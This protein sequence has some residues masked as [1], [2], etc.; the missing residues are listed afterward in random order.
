MA[1]RWLFAQNYAIR[2]D[3][4]IDLDIFVPF[5]SLPA[6]NPFL[7]FI[8]GDKRFEDEDSDE[9]AAFDLIAVDAALQG[10]AINLW[11]LNPN[12][13]D[14]IAHFKR[15]S[16]TSYTDKQ[17]SKTKDYKI[18]NGGRCTLDRNVKPFGNGYKLIA[19]SCTMASY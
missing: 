15:D 17:P 13:F 19:L 16:I 7:E 9:W 5:S 11:I 1:V 6:I 8:G 4:D 3:S 2:E 18:F 10:V 12:T 14:D